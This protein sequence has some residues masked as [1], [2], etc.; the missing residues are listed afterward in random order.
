LTDRDR[1]EERAALWAI[2]T[3][4]CRSFVVQGLQLVTEQSAKVETSLT[5]DD[6]AAWNCG[7]CYP[8]K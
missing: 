2:E 5:G 7:K 6:A 3:G 4:R 1:C 8:T